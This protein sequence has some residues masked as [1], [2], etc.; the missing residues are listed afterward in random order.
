M[1]FVSDEIPVTALL[2]PACSTGYGIESEG[3]KSTSPWYRYTTEYYSAIRTKE[4]M[5]STETWM[6]LE[7]K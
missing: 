5:P 3:R 4:I 6:D 1:S 7:Y 2:A